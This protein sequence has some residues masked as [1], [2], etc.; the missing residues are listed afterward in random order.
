GIIGKFITNW[1]NFHLNR[2]QPCREL[3]GIMFQQEADKAFMGAQ[4][5]P[6]DNQRSFRFIVFVGKL[7][8]KSSSLGKIHLVGSKSEFTSNGA[9][10]LHVDFWTVKCCFIRYLNKRCTRFN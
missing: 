6:V 8:V 7:K 2:S 10:N 1:Q 4:W 9:V 3:S 5:R